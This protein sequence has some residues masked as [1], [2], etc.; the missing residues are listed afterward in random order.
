MGKGL[1]CT[2]PGC[3][4]KSRNTIKPGLCGSHQWQK[5]QK[6][7]LTPIRERNP[8]NTKEDLRRIFRKYTVRVPAPSYE[9]C[10]YDLSDRGLCRI[11]TRSRDVNT[12][13]AKQKW[14]GENQ[15]AHRLA[16]WVRYGELDDDDLILHMCGRGA[17]GCINPRHLYKGNHQLN[18]DDAVA[19][20]RHTRGERSYTAKLTDSI[21]REAREIWTGGATARELADYYGVAG[22]T[23]QRALNGDTWKHVK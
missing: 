18:S 10:G 9:E 6:G 13:Y 2:F 12:G 1:P 4:N 3:P 20:D 16:Y 8:I 14:D 15:L 23:M 17:D 5:N 7:V 19:V 21:V 11:W 22:S